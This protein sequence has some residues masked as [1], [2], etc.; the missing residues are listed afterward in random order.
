MT[1][2]RP[3][4]G[5]ESWK[6]ERETVSPTPSVMSGNDEGGVFAIGDDIPSLPCAE[7][8]D[9]LGLPLDPTA[10]GADGVRPIPSLRGYR[11]SALGN[12]YGRRG[13]CLSLQ[14]AKGHSFVKVEG[15]DGRTTH[16]VSHLVLEAFHGKP[17][18]PGF[19]AQHLDGNRQNNRLSNLLWG[20]RRDVAQASMRDGTHP[21]L[22][23]GELH[24]SAK[25]SDANVAAIIALKGSDMPTRTI[26]EHFGVTASRVRQL[27]QRG[28]AAS[29]RTGGTQEISEASVPDRPLS[30]NSSCGGIGAKKSDA[31]RPD[32]P[33]HLIAALSTRSK[34][35]ENG[36]AT[37]ACSSDPR[38]D[39]F[40]PASSRTDR[41]GAA[42]T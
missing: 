28:R 8:S 4:V 35:R 5:T 41:A 39:A 37:S 10:N 34:Q 25:L 20:T 40:N 6:V 26:A 27:W 1:I 22:R 2:K 13:E 23:R 29:N 17:L 36:A 42:M 14:I 7:V 32:A 19:V 12:I 21:C 31:P 33:A 38:G 11:A 9:Q 3:G 24:L 15:D 30:T 18:Q 16:R